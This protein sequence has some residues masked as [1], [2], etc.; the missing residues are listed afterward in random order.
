MHKDQHRHFLTYTLEH[1]IGAAF[2]I[3]LS[4]TVG[5][6][7]Q[8]QSTPGGTSSSTAYT[9]DTIPPTA[10]VLH[11]MTVTTSSISLSWEGATDNV[12]VAGYRLFKN[13]ALLAN[14]TG[15]S[16]NDVSNLTPGSTIGYYVV[17]V[18]SAGNVSPQS[19]TSIVQMP[20]SN[21][22]TSLD[23][24]LTPPVLQLGTV[25]TGKVDL[26]W[27]VP[28]TSGYTV[29][30][31]Y[32]IYRNNSL[33]ANVT[34]TSYIDSASLLPGTSYFYYVK[35]VSSAGAASLPSN[36]VTAMMPVT[37]TTALPPTGSLL[38][39][40]FGAT[41]API[42][43]CTTGKP[44]T[45]VFLVTS[46]AAGGKFQI[47]SDTG[48]SNAPFELGRYPLSNGHYYWKA[49]PASGYTVMGD[50]AGTFTL[51]GECI[52]PAITQSTPQAIATSGTPTTAT[53]PA[54]NIMT[55]DTF[56]L[57]Y[58]E[59]LLI[60]PTVSIDNV[61]LNAT[62]PVSGN[63][64]FD[65]VALGMTRAIFVIESI[66]T[67]KQFIDKNL[68]VVHKDATSEW[69]VVWNSANMPNGDYTL[70]ALT[71][72][73]AG[74][75][76]ISKRVSFIARNQ[77]TE[78]SAGTG[79]VNTSA[80]V[81][82]VIKIFVD[83]S[84]VPQGTLDFNNETVELR[85]AS[86]NAKN[87]HFF[88]SVSGKSTPIELGKGE[89]DD[90]LSGHAYDI[91]T[92]SVDTNE[93]EQ[94]S[95]KL[96]ARVLY[97]D[98]TV[99][100]SSPILMKV[101]HASDLLSANRDG[102]G[103]STTLGD[104]VLTAAQKE[105][106]LAR[107]TKPGECTNTLE[108]SVYCKSA[109]SST[110]ACHA[111]VRYRGKEIVVASLAGDVSKER[112]EDML[113][114]PKKRLKN[115]PSA[116]MHAQDMVDY[117]AD[118]SHADIC[119]R[120]LER[121][122]LISTSTL[123]EKI[124]Q[125][126]VSRDAEKALFTERIGARAFIDTDKDGITDYDEVNLYHTSPNDTDTD[127]DGVPDDE[128]LLEHTNP[129]GRD[130]LAINIDHA[131]HTP[132][133]S[134]S[135]TGTSVFSRPASEGVIHEDPRIAGVTQ[136]SL[137]AVND[138][139]AQEIGYDEHGTS[140]V[141]KIKFSGSALPNSYITLYIFSNP[142]VVT[143][144]ADAAGEWTYTLDKELPNGSHQVV[145]AITNEGGHILAKSE[146]LPFV[147]EAAAVSVGANALLPN[148]TTP[149]FF[150]SASLYAFIAILIGLLGVAFSIIGFV[151]HQRSPAGGDVLFPDAKKDD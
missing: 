52:A 96:F 56:P 116:V 37:S 4:A 118:P 23:P 54:I 147:K 18:D 111:F 131:S 120:A 119:S 67:G 77:T 110:A 12:G 112:L 134:G 113:A 62:D 14:L 101:N 129:N 105:E 69:S 151:V 3:V 122:D 123:E 43:D 35:S 91:W 76:F 24:T 107:V 28:A 74:T 33:I 25:T 150:T 21:T 132:G 42:T 40:S 8:A 9:P 6:V 117:C 72:N 26:L 128:E 100:E 16:Y 121:N 139:V 80:Q 27:T 65:V 140:T 13:G 59:N 124:K 71:D 75:T 78:A 15:N 19:N 104:G 102:S 49:V 61:R 70:F 64:T 94:N 99:A 20:I 126:I 45:E 86:A 98:G 66:K 60:I 145:S 48:F 41:V 53:L 88:A 46:D 136:K 89:I 93:I 114:D 90:L 30:Y 95:Y 146:P 97:L 82:P 133:T 106:I 148:Q 85:V 144:K 31:G 5:Y 92:L 138:V 108:C 141:K 149:G 58:A 38:T 81:R 115:L 39:V 103:V 68:G 109:A 17:A 2:I 29:P 63:V 34:T 44:L 137:L 143:V 125:L 50:S 22:T 10:P 32:S 83:N 127:H 135:S 73:S 1:L 142:I 7:A 84:P 47:T 11:L 57:K 79:I 87:V 130:A 36:T 51:S 55:G